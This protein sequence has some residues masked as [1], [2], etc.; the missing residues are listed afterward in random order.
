VLANADTKPTAADHASSAQKVDAVVHNL[1]G[2][3]HAMEYSTDAE[4]HCFFYGPCVDTSQLQ[5]RVSA[6]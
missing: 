4:G 6:R 1:N 2:N 3:V 5:G